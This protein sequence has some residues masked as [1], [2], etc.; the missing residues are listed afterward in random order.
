MQTV[1]A[2]WAS[3]SFLIYLGGLTVFGAVIGLLGVQ[4][5]DYRPAAFVLWALLIFVAVTAS[6][7]AFRRRAHFV[8]AGL[9]ALSSVGAFVVLFGALL[10][11][12][13]WLP[14]VGLSFRGFHFWVLVLELAVVVAAA[15]ALRNFGFPLFVFVIATASWYFVT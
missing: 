10:D 1:R 2:P 3:A 9:L 6:A 15:V 4:Y 14:H 8:T 5:A 12:F 13:G 11:W 7:V